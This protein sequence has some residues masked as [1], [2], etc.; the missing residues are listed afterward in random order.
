MESGRET[1]L[2]LRSVT[3]LS[4]KQQETPITILNRNKNENT[5]RRKK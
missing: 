3:V 4:A 1:S 5:D 2:P